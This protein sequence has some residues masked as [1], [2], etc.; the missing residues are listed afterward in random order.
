MNFLGYR[1]LGAWD[2]N[3]GD[4]RIIKFYQGPEANEPLQYLSPCCLIMCV[5]LH[6]H[7]HD[8]SPRV[9]Y[10]F[11]CAHVAEVTERFGGT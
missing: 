8:H 7:V 2:G 10:E 3:G 6:V 9:S 5:S 4:Q 11:R 1:V